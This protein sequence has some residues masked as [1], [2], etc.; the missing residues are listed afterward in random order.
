VC[1]CGFIHEPPQGARPVWALHV[2]TAKCRPRGILLWIY[3]ASSGL[4]KP[5]WSRDEQCPRASRTCHSREQL[6]TAEL[7]NIMQTNL[8]APIYLTRAITRQWLNV[9]VKLSES[10]D[11]RGKRDEQIDLKKKIILISSISGQIVNR[12]QCQMAYNASKA[13][14]TMVGKVSDCC[15]CLTRRIARG[16]GWRGQQRGGGWSRGVEGQNAWAQVC[17]CRD[18]PE[19]GTKAGRT[20]RQNQAQNRSCSQTTTRTPTYNADP[21]A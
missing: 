18:A 10:S 17:P 15:G 3:R 11:V 5:S 4:T 13:G 2:D 19:R 7:D 1:H 14:L 12:P 16:E 21:S 9:P 8:Y 20:G 6:T